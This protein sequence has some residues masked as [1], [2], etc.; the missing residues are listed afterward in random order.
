ME[1]NNPVT[2]YLH[3]PGPISF[4]QKE[5]LL[6]WSSH[7]SAEYFKHEYLPKGENPDHYDQ[8]IM[9]EVALGNMVPMDIAK[10]K[11]NGIEGRKS[12]DAMAAYTISENQ[13][14][15]EVLLD[16][17]LSEGT[18]DAMIVEWNSYRYKSYTGASGQKGIMLFALSKRG[19]GAQGKTFAS[20]ITSNRKK[21]SDEFEGVVY[22]VIK[23]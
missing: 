18:G 15:G 9:L 8:M 4:N 20:D 22:P 6:S 16:F 11:A 5:Y 17:M 13:K 12:A 2:D 10:G 3:V 21:Y 19:Y 1:P 14:T 7:P 23:L